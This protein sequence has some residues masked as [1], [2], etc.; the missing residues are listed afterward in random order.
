MHQVQRNHS[1]Y[2]YAVYAYDGTYHTVPAGE[3]CRPLDPISNGGI[4]YSDLL[5]VPGVVAHYV[6]LDGYVLHGHGKRECAPDGGWMNSEMGNPVCRGM[7]VDIRFNIQ[8]H[9]AWTRTVEGQYHYFYYYCL[10]FISEM[11]TSRT[12]T[13]WPCALRSS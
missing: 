3:T 11:S 13:L 5:L 8:N 6:C 10:R 1:F 2:A 9:H 12:N 7:R 4:I